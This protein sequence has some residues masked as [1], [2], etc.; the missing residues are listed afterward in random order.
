MTPSSTA[1]ARVADRSAFTLIEILIS[2]TVIA[3][4]AVLILAASGVVRERVR[5]SEA[6]QMVQ[7][8]HQALMTY[9]AED[10]QR[11]YPPPDADDTLRSGLVIGQAATALDWCATR[12]LVALPVADCAP[13]GDAHPGAIL[14][15]WR[16]PYR[17]R[18]DANMDGVAQRPAALSDW[19]PR[20]Q[21]PFPYLWSDAGESGASPTT[22]FY[23]VGTPP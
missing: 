17:Y 8:L 1:I 3:I 18:L 22:W 11:R 2:V 5:R 10:L 6:R 14:D 9:A 4:L 19:N 12:G 20:G 21:E 13:A 15:P 7:A 16:R 23:V